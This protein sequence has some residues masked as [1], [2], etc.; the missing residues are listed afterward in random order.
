MGCCHHALARP[1]LAPTDCKWLARIVCH[2]SPWPLPPFG[3]W[4][5]GANGGNDVSRYDLRAEAIPDAALTV[6]DDR[7]HDRQVEV[8]D[9]DEEL[10]AVAGR[11]VVRVFATTDI[12]LSEMPGEAILTLDIGVVE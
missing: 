5:I 8:G 6:V 9:N 1:C 12:E 10:S 11:G 4:I 7:E 3:R 2:R